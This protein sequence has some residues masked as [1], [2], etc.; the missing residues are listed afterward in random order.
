[1][2]RNTI[3]QSDALA[4]L[5]SL[6]DE[7]VN[8]I[9]TSPPYY[10]LRDYGVDGQLGM[11]PTL[12]EYLDRLTAVFHEA[13]RVLRSDGCAWV[14]MGDSYANDEKWG[15]NASGKQ[16]YMGQAING[17]RSRRCTELPGKNL[18][19]VPWRLAFALQDGGW[20]LRSDIIWAKPNPMPES[21]T[22][23]PT[24]SH[25]YIFLL[26]KNGH[27]WYDADAVREAQT[28]NAHARGNGSSP[29]ADGIS[30]NMARNNTS[31]NTSMTRYV[32]VPGGRNLRTVWTLSTEANSF[33]HFATFPRK[34]VERCV[35]AGCPAQV[36]AQCGAPFM[37]VVEREPMIINRSDRKNVMGEYG[38]TQSSGTMVAPATSKTIG[39]QPTCTCNAAT[40]PG[41]VLDPFMGSGTTALVARAL[42]RD[43]IGSDLSAE[44]VQLAE[45]RLAAPWQPAL[46]V[47]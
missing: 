23:R 12:R 25:E 15:G 32:D 43:F 26:S 28:G 22:D 44:Y 33:A 47:E 24:K 38:R 19:G 16:A 17:P 10:A 40:R 2:Q 29:K 14:N 21:V 39:F 20:Y 42:G 4:F 11:E 46:F 6:P 30:R 34:L 18:L 13:R 36:C 8:C 31:F 7:S 1:M 37:R 9:V 3:V 45:T 35:K 5:Q 41:I 27:Y